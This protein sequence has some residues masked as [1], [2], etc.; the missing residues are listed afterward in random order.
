M[1]TLLVAVS[2]IISN[3]VRAGARYCCHA[4]NTVHWVAAMS[5]L[6]FGVFEVLEGFCMTFQRGDDLELAV[7]A[8]ADY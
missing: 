3:A 2:A 4:P 7:F 1:P 5:I 6:Y 8:D